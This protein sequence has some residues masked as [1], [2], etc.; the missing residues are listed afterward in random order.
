MTSTKVV[1]VAIPSIVENYLQ[2]SVSRNCL[3]ERERERERKNGSEGEFSS[4]TK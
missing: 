2:R 1:S 4:S 3:G